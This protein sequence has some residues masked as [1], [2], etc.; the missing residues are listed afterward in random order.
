[1]FEAK[2]PVSLPSLESA[3][4]P[5]NQ[6]S[7]THRNPRKTRRHREKEE[8]DWAHTYTAHMAVAEGRALVVGVT[9]VCKKPRK[10][11]SQNTKTQ[12]TCGH[13]VEEDQRAWEPPPP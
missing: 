5:R 8:R 13:Q 7:Q 11:N 12:E 1:M 3:R 10:P 2:K 6:N 4:K 9:Q